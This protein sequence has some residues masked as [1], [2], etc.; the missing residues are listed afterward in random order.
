[1]KL[2]V[3]SKGLGKNLRF[4]NAETGEEI[5]IDGVERVDW[6]QDRGPARLVVTL[7]EFEIQAEGPFKTRRPPMEPEG[8][9]DA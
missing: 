2:K 4:E 9:Q 7:L 6:S 3:I 5:Q 1:M 8:A